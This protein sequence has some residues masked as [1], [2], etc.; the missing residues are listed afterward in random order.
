MPIPGEPQH[1]SDRC[2]TRHAAKQQPSLPCPYFRVSV[3][4]GAVRACVVRTS[5]SCASNCSRLAT[6]T[7]MPSGSA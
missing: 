7:A 5:L 6:R 1:G 4:S 2:A 3:A